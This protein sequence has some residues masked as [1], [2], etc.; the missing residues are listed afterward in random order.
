MKVG[1]GADLSRL[2]PEFLKRSSFLNSPVTV[3]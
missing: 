2:G 1:R 3:V